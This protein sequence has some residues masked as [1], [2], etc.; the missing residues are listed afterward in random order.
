MTTAGTRLANRRTGTSWESMSP[1][2][3]PP[4]WKNTTVGNGPSPA[5]TYTRTGMSPAGP[6]T[7]TSST[8]ARSSAGPDSSAIIAMSAR[9]SSTETVSGGGAPVSAI[10]LSS[11]SHCGSSGT[12]E[13]LSGE[14]G[15]DALADLDGLL[16]LGEMTGVVDQRDLGVADL[17]REL[18]GVDARHEAVLLAPHEQRRRRHPVHPAVEALVGD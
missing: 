13:P 14:E 7:L 15:Q 16:E 3:Q 1:M 12:E 17:G 8:R 6:G 4:P 11:A 2:T 10:W 5:G 9:L 18:V